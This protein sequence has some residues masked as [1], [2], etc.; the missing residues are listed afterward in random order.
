MIVLDAIALLAMDGPL[1]TTRAVA[2]I[3]G[4]T[5]MAIQHRHSMPEIEGERFVTFQ[6]LVNP[7]E[8]LAQI[9][10]PELG[11]DTSNRVDAAQGLAQPLLPET[12]PRNGLYRMEASQLR[13]KHDQG[14]F[15][16]HHRGNPRRKPPI[17]DLLKNAIRSVEDL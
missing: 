11:V 4:V 5:L 6:P 13:P 10:S 3:A 2:P 17:G 12:S 15:Q 8:A 14:G 1:Q 16:P 9:G 7:V